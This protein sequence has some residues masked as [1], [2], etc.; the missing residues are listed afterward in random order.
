MLHDL[1]VNSD[2]VTLKPTQ[3]NSCR[4][5]DVEIHK[6]HNRFTALWIL[7]GTIRVSR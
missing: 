1:N 6:T 3:T 2:Y 4:M 5:D 7:S